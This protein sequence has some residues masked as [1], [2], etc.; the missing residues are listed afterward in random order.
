MKYFNRNYMIQN[1]KKSKAILAFF[2]GMIPILSIL[3]CLTLFTNSNYD[4]IS[5][6]SISIVHYIGI[7]L[8][9]IILSISLFGFVYKKKSVD[10]INSMPISRKSIFTTNTI[11]GI[12]LLI[13]MVVFSAFGIYITSIFS[14][15]ILSFRMIVD[16]IILWSITYSFIFIL[17][18]IAMSISGNRITQIIVTLLLLFFMPFMLQYTFF[19]HGNYQDYHLCFDSINSNCY[20]VYD[21]NNF[22][23]TLPYNLI[24][25]TLF[26]SSMN[27]LWN[28]IVLIKMFIISILGYFLGKFLFSI[29]KMEINETSFSNLKVHNFVKGLTLVPIV[30]IIMEMIPEGNKPIL[31]FIFILVLLLIYYFIYD[32][33]TKRQITQISKSLIHFLITIMILFSFCGILTNR[34]HYDVSNSHEITMTE[35][36][37]TGYRFSLFT[38][39]LTDFDYV[40]IKNKDTIHMITNVLQ[41]KQNYRSD[42]VVKNIMVF[43]KNK[44]YQFEV[45]FSQEDYQKIVEQIKKTEDI[46]KTKT[47][48]DKGNI[49]A[50]YFNHWGFIKIT[51]DSQVLTAAKEAILNQ[52][53]TIDTTLEVD[54]YLYVYY[55]GQIYSYPIST[56]YSKK[57]NQYVQ[58]SIQS[59]QQE[60]LDQLKNIGY[61]EAIEGHNSFT[62]KLIA[63]PEN[64][65]DLSFTDFS[66]LVTQNN[67]LVYQ[68][69]K[70]HQHDSFTTD[71]KYVTL[72]I[73]FRFK[74]YVYHTNQVSEFIEMLEAVKDDNNDIN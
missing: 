58:E 65:T 68:F 2:L 73:S 74:E 67:D 7:Y 64:S 44:P 63:F 57:L 42:S 61:Q 53:Q 19:Y 33:I 70:E 9:P 39:E 13:S 48:L 69:L 66:L 35:E 47:V 24:I 25:T 62:A 55:N 21:Q 50:I 32:L 31:L 54:N 52:N 18:N 27:Q 1:I 17:A 72:R 71:K 36:N 49:Y 41:E 15:V 26:G 16:Y 29:R 5:L 37:I 6:E 30:A 38:T 28:V 60:F 8:I 10:F 51:N 11:T 56:K 59:E 43:I 34:H 12:L 40:D 14:H 46:Q 4:A 20:W 23:Y 45:Y 22:P 3:A